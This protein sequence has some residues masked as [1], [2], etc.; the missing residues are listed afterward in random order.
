MFS[1]LLPVIAIGLAL[2]ISGL[3][4][5]KEFERAVIFRLGRLVGARGPGVV[6]VLPVIERM[7]RVDLRTVT[8]DVPPQD[9]ITRDNVSVKVNAV[10]YFRV[11]DPQRAIVEVADYLFA[12]SQL[13]QTTLRSVCGQREL[14]EL[15][16][17]RDEINQHIQQ[18]LDTQTDSWGIKVTT[19]EIKHIDLPQ[20]MQRAMA[21]QA[22]AER[23]RRAKVINAEGEFQAAQ[24]LAEAA[25]IIAAHPAALQLR[26]LQTLA[27]VATEHNS[28]TLFPL[29]FDLLK[30]FI[31][32]EEKDPT[33]G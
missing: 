33:K 3:K 25:H 15:L 4:V 28:T 23:E 1:P 31:K 6:Y 20:E 7:E 16:S 2:L 9:V 18:T 11:V 26:F 17:E 10:L 30:P 32:A 8:M 12:T 5:L 22:E 27:E 19:V 24:R 13:A 14:D 29:P 21:R